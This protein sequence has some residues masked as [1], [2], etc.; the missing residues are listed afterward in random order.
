[1]VSYI[2]NLLRKLM[3]IIMAILI[4]STFIIFFYSALFLRK[5][6]DSFDHTSAFIDG[7]PYR[8]S[9]LHIS[10]D[11]F[12]NRKAYGNIKLIPDGI[13]ALTTGFI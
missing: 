9:F 11:K 5:Y 13:H 7:P 6:E 10:I 8:N 1:M 3:E 12:E 2:R 4:V